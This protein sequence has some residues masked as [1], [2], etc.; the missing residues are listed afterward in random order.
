MLLAGYSLSIKDKRIMKKI[1]QGDLSLSPSL[2]SA[3]GNKDNLL[4]LQVNSDL[5]DTGQR[6][7]IF[8]EDQRAKLQKSRADRAEPLNAKESSSSVQHESAKEHALSNERKQKE[9]QDLQDVVITEEQRKEWKARKL[10]A[11]QD[12]NAKCLVKEPPAT[13]PPRSTRVASLD[14]LPLSFTAEKSVMDMQYCVKNLAEFH[15]LAGKNKLSKFS[16]FWAPGH[17]NTT[18]LKPAFTPEKLMTDKVPLLSRLYNSG[19]TTADGEADPLNPPYFR[20]SRELM[21]RIIHTLRLEYISDDE[22]SRMSTEFKEHM[23]DVLAPLKATLASEVTRLDEHHALSVRQHEKLIKETHDYLAEA[24]EKFK[25]ALEQQVH[26]MTMH[27]DRKEEMAERIKTLATQARKEFRNVC[28]ASSLEASPVGA[29]SLEAAGGPNR[30]APVLSSE[31]RATA[32]EEKNAHKTATEYLLEESYKDLKK[33]QAKWDEEGSELRK[34]IKLLEN[35]R[36]KLMNQ[37]SARC[38]CQ[39][40]PEEARAC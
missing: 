19:Q 10:K 34:K 9:L 31:E 5:E 6:M 36:E 15:T 25:L 30:V 39:K 2:V 14:D 7:P 33:R 20:I 4:S 40:L 29:S 26:E 35:E 18:P 32:R 16:D 11:A 21:R 27:T 8:T 1:R 22:N 17:Q 38:Q 37:M 28:F 12:E 23:D 13:R 3:S 24:S